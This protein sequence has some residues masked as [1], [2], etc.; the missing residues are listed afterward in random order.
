M[1]RVC[2]TCWK[3][4]CQQ[5]GSCVLV[6]PRATLCVCFQPPP[7][8]TCS[9]FFVALDLGPSSRWD[10]IWSSAALPGVQGAVCVQE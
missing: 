1:F 3:Y 10:G 5:P 4:L 8:M 6:Q 9:V 2:V 7:A